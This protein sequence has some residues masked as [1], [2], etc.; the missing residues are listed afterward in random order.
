[1]REHL[2]LWA[3]SATLVP[4]PAK[5]CESA[6]QATAIGA[7]RAQRA[8]FN[9]AIAKR[10]IEAVAATLHENVILVTGTAS[11]V[12]T[13]R[14]AQRSLWQRDFESPGR[15]VYVRMTDC[16][17]VSEVAPVALESGR[18]RGVREGQADASAA[19]NFAAGVYSAK[20]RRVD[21]TW[22]LEAEIFATETCGGDFCPVDDGDQP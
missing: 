10:D 2:I 9:E 4:S 20:W 18:W 13:G 21:G 1:M 6:G 17:R 7:V 8:A 22:L 14:A 12:F 5:A 15:A 16:V 19:G 3:L 11:E